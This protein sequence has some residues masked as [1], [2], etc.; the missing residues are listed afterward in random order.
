[1]C[2]EKAIKVL[3][4]GAVKAYFFREKIVG[5]LSFCETRN[6]ILDT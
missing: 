3:Q 4:G 1:M 2:D 5:P 6:L